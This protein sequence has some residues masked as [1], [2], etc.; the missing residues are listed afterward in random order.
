[1]AARVVPGQQ[2]GKVLLELGRTS[3]SLSLALL[4]LVLTLLTEERPGV[5]IT[6]G[7][8]PQVYAP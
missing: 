8:P 7:E 4:G 1:M 2:V 3:L 6:I 5:E